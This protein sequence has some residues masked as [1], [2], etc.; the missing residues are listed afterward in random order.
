[1]PMLFTPE[2]IKQQTRDL[3]RTCFHD[4]E[5]F[6]DIYFEEKY[7]DASNITVRQDGRVVAAAQVLPYRMTFYGVVL[8]VGYLSGLCV[9]PEWRG[10]GLAA[11]V[12]REAH[13]RLYQQGAALSFLIP[14]DEGLRK[15]YEQPVHG[16]YWT[17]TFRSE[18]EMADTGEDDLRIEVLRPDEWGNDLYVYVRQGYYTEFMLH[19]SESDFFA[20]LRLCDLEN[21][22][23]LV[24]RRKRSIKG[25]CL[26]VVEPD[27]KCVIRTILISLP[28]VKNLFVRYLKEHAGVEHVWARVPIPGSLSKSTPYGMARVVNAERFLRVVLAAQPDFQLHIGVGGDLDVPENNGYY[29][30]FGGQLTITESKPDSIVTPGGLAAMFLGAQPTYM[31]M[32][33]DE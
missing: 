9:A 31:E 21:G 30:I 33:L 7:T 16:A 12:I 26:A 2:E 29:R 15:F 22:Y 25:I 19:P 10:R 18:V 17:S 3:W 14:G 20:A 1:M 6:M 32:M 13:R 28:V 24:A 23:V 4:S 8:R 27:G 5:E 11:Q